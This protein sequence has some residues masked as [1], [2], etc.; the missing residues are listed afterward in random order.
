[1]ILL[2]LAAVIS[3]ACG[4]NNAQV[5]TVA[6]EVAYDQD[7]YQ[8]AYFAA[9]CFWCV[10]AVFES[11]EGVEEAISGYSGG[12]EK[13]PTYDDV[14]YGRTSHAE[15]VEV[16]YDPAVVSYA[17]LL[18][19][20]YGSHNPTTVNGQK[21]D[22]GRQYRSMI[23]YTNDEEKALA[24]AFKDQLDASGQFGSPIAT[25]IVAFKKFWK[26]EA[27]HQNFERLNP[28]NSYVKSVSIPRLNRFKAK[29]PHLL[30]KNH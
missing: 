25:E 5:D 17:T 3:T 11:V 13:N 12:K 14:G 15:A 26:A 9:G 29:F 28:N 30:K 6:I 4:S 19:V 2:F 7:K 22:F 24:T 27:Y 20:Y 16:I 8:K 23:Y 10:E 18:E 1:M 21:P